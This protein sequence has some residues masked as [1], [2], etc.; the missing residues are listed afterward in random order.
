MVFVANK[1]W[2]RILILTLDLRSPDR[3]LGKDLHLLHP[4]GYLSPIYKGS[5]TALRSGFKTMEDQ[6]PIY[7]ISLVLTL[8]SFEGG[9]EANVI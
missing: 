2:F 9:E 3:Y 6:R 4:N 1:F 8:R 5:T 7:I